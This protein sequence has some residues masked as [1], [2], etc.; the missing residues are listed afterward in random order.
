MFHAGASQEI[1]LNDDRLRA[2]L[3]S[4]ADQITELM[5]RLKLARMEGPD[6]E[7][8]RREFRHMAL[9]AEHGARRGLLQLSDPSLTRRAMR[10][11][12]AAIEAEFPSLWLARNRSGGLVDALGQLAEL[13]PLYEDGA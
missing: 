5:A 10:E 4:T 8:I 7:L 9:M 2:N 3:R 6:A 13:R 12:L 1:L 11:E